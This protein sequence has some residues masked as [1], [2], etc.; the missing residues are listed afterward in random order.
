MIFKH[1]HFIASNLVLLCFVIGYPTPLLD[2]S[3]S[4]RFFSSSVVFVYYHYS[5]YYYL[6]PLGII[7][8]SPP[9]FFVE[10]IHALSSPLY[11]AFRT[12]PVRNIH[13]KKWET[14]NLNKQNYQKRN[15]T[16]QT[17]IKE[18]HL[19]FFFKNVII[20]IINLLGKLKIGAIKKINPF[21]RIFYSI[22]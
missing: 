17:Y 12:H 8:F 5:Y 3:F 21:I 11:D 19:F 6:S 1:F 15:N 2:L 14:L 13:K 9:F 16:T 20:I 10:V 7:S 18:L 4:F 22:T